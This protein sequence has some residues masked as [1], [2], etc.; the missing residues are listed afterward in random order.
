[1]PVETPYIIVSHLFP[2]SVAMLEKSWFTPVG[3][4]LSSYGCS[5]KFG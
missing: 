4:H 2:I 3:V 1:M 5:L